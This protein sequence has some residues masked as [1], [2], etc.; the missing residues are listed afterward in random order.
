MDKRSTAHLVDSRTDKVMD[1]LTAVGVPLAFIRK[2]ICTP[3]IPELAYGTPRSSWVQYIIYLYK[4]ENTMHKSNVHQAPK[5]APTELEVLTMKHRD[6][7]ARHE[8]AAKVLEGQQNEAAN[9]LL[10]ANT[11]AEEL[12]KAKLTAAISLIRRVYTE[13]PAG[14]AASVDIVQAV[15]DI[16]TVEAVRSGNAW[17]TYYGL[18]SASNPN[19]QNIPKPYGSLVFAAPYG[20]N[21]PKDQD[22]VTKQTVANMQTAVS[23]HGV[24]T[25]PVTP[26]IPRAEVCAT[27]REQKDANSDAWRL[28]EARGTE[29]EYVLHKDFGPMLFVPKDGITSVPQVDT[30]QKW[31]IRVPVDGSYSSIALVHIP[32]GAVTKGFPD[33]KAVFRYIKGRHATGAAHWTDKTSN[34]GMETEYE[35]WMYTKYD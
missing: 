26:V 25:R 8:H 33:M 6:A 27:A 15:T 1:T 5:P 30:L 18:L 16:Y 24:S 19:P 14:S 28:A 34:G 7:V 10:A 21:I 20:S 12:G 29:Y 4:K 35:A 17:A 22:S 9:A 3:Y 11:A 32:T 2:H 23:T 13:A 31:A